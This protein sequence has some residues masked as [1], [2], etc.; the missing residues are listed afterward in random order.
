MSAE[1]RDLLFLLGELFIATVALTGIIMVLL[2]TRSES[3]VTQGAQLAYILRMSSTV[4]IFAVFPLIV[5]KCGLE[6]HLLWRVSSGTYLCTLL[7]FAGR[8]FLSDDPTYQVAKRAQILIGLTGLIAMGTLISNLI[9]AG[10]T[11]HIVQLFIAWV[12][13]MLLFRSFILEALVERQTDR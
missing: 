10:A 1:T 2:S 11:L 9:I 4:T 8:A 5:E 6:G 12:T 7:Y 3:R 13:S